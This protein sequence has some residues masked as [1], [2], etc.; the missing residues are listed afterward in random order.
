MYIEKN[1]PLGAQLRDTS[2][3][4]KYFIDGSLN[5]S[6]KE[7]LTGIEGMTMEFLAL[8]ENEE[9]TASHY[10]KVANISKATVSQ[11]LT[12]MEKK[13]LIKMEPSKKD[14]RKKVISFTKKGREVSDSFDKAFIKINCQIEKGL[15]D[16]DK[17][18]LVRLLNKIKNNV[19][20]KKKD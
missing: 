10:M 4:I 13:G 15:T 18:E 3:C 5:K 6:I 17:K 16:K 7:K 11:I 8:H 2:H 1:K 19:S 12:G 20:L 14:K 9:V